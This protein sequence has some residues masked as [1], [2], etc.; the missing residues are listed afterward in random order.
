MD[1]TWTRSNTL[2]ELNFADTGGIAESMEFEERT[3][4]T[5]LYHGSSHNNDNFVV[6][7]ESPKPGQK[8][9][10]RHQNLLEFAEMILCGESNVNPKSAKS[11][12]IDS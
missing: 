11:E 2:L 5:S 10:V 3:S 4:G 12:E 1:T 6:A 9:K 7:S 8:L